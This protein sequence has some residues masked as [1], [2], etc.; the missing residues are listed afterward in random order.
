MQGAIFEEE[1]KA[2]QNYIQSLYDKMDQDKQ[3]DLERVFSLI[4]SY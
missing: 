3:D 1:K 4:S 2:K